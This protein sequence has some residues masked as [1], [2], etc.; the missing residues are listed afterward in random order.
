MLVPVSSNITRS[1][2]SVGERISG[3]FLGNETRFKPPVAVL[4]RLIAAL[5]HYGQT[6]PDGR[7][8]KNGS[9]AMADFVVAAFAS[10]FMRSPSFLAR[11]RYI[12]TTQGRSISQTLF[13]VG[14]IPGDDPAIEPFRAGIALDTLTERHRHGKKWTTYPFGQKKCPEAWSTPGSRHN[15][16]CWTRVS[17][18]PGASFL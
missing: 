5:R 12:E 16:N 18:R 9:Y 4:D 13:G 14:K 17:R 2:Q 11:Q 7:Q 3:V 10:F 6:L 1:R 8:G 15:Q